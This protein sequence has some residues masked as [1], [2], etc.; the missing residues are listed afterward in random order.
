MSHLQYFNYPGVG[1]ENQKNY[2]YSQA[3]KIGDKI[4]CSGQGE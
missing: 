2:K 4:E 1:V 3:V